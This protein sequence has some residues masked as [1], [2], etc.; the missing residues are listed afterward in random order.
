MN[1]TELPHYWVLMWQNVD[2]IL[3]RYNRHRAHAL[4]ITAD[5]V[6]VYPRLPIPCAADLRLEATLYP[7]KATTQNQILESV[8][9]RLADRHPNASTV[10]VSLLWGGLEGR[11][12]KTLLTLGG[13]EIAS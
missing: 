5:G 12:L 9:V 4:N 11:K 2:G 13:K 8:I 6:E 3:E 10:V 7:S 1:W